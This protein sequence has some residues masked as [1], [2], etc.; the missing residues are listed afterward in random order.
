MIYEPTISEVARARRYL[1]KKSLPTIPITSQ[2]VSVITA[3]ARRL[4]NA[5]G[6]RRGPGQNTH[7]HNRACNTPDVDERAGLEPQPSLRIRTYSFNAVTNGHFTTTKQAPGHQP[8]HGMVESSASETI[9]GGEAR[10]FSSYPNRALRTE[11]RNAIDLEDMAADFIRS[12]DAKRSGTLGA[13]A[14]DQ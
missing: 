13:V 12:E 11:G 4:G 6:F 5:I 8:D 2:G 14:K 9:P 3:F 7:R 1:E 10:Q